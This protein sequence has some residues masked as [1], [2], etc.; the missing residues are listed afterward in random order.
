[1][2]QTYLLVNTDGSLERIQT[3]GIMKLQQMQHLVGGY[4]EFVRMAEG[5]V[6]CMINEE[7]RL[8]GLPDNARYPNLC[9]PIVF[10]RM[11]E[12]PDNA[13]S[14][15]GPDSEFLGLNEELLRVLE[16]GGRFGANVATTQYMDRS[17]TIP[18]SELGIR[19]ES[20]ADVIANDPLK[21]KGKG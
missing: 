14:E 15:D 3:D 1:M 11:G 4:I 18:D 10:G 13:M 17:K 6:G 21:P 8:R 20:L 2:T 19:V 5:G 9:G 12:D 7:G 16:G